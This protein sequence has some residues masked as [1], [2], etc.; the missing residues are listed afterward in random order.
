MI[1]LMMMMGLHGR[2]SESV[3]TKCEKDDVK[4]YLKKYSYR[5]VSRRWCSG[6]RAICRC[7]DVLSSAK[8]LSLDTDTLSYLL[9][10]NDLVYANTDMGSESDDYE[11]EDDEDAATEVEMED[12]CDYKMIEEEEEEEGEEDFDGCSSVKSNVSTSNHV[13]KQ[14]QIKD[15]TRS[16]FKK[17]RH[18]FSGIYAKIKNGILNNF[19]TYGSSISSNGGSIS[20]IEEGS[21]NDTATATTLLDR[22][23]CCS[24][25]MISTGTGTTPSTGIG[26]EISSYSYYHTFSSSSGD[27]SGY[28]M[29][30]TS[31]A[32]T[33]VFCPL[34]RT[35]R[36]MSSTKFS[37]EDDYSSMINQD[38]IESN[39]MNHR[40]GNKIS[41]TNILKLLNPI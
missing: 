3:R 28:R 14:H 5:Q 41:S 11:D 39:D 9:Q 19:K 22:M 21:I 29:K 16:L 33:T 25:G 15:K 38:E 24:R 26:P 37:D 17:D 31:P 18:I 1:M 32:I 23:R 36:S 40:Y 4:V 34:T 35:P 13:R 20:T 12:E 30:T 7:G 6:T 27:V 10:L 2:V 8:H